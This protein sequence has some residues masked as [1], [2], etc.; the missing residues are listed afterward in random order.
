MEP[1]LAHVTRRIYLMAFCGRR[2]HWSLM[3][4]QSFRRHERMCPAG[5]I[6]ERG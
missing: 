5:H 6:L 2:W 4:R 1:A 3:T